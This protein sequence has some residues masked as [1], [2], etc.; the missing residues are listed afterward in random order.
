MTLSRP[1]RHDWIISILLISGLGLA[2]WLSRAALSGPFL[3]DDFPN[4][5]NLREI[6]GCFN[7]DRIANYLAVFT[8]TP[9]RPLSALSFLIDD[10]A[11][12]STPYSWKRH[13]LL[14]HLLCGLLVFGL[15]RSLASVRHTRKTSDWVGMGVA[16]AWLVHPMQLST[17]MLT[18]QRMTQL[19]TM[20]S[21][22]TCWWV[23][24]R[25]L[26]RPRIWKEYAKLLVIGGAMT[27]VAFLFKENGALLPLYLAA[28]S[29]WVLQDRQIPISRS[30]RAYFIVLSLPVAAII[31]ALAYTA[32]THQSDG[33]R[34]FNPWERLLTEGRILLDY[35]RQILFPRLNG[36][37][38]FHDDIVVSRG[39]LSPPTTL[40]ALLALL[41]LFL[42]TAVKRK[43]WPILAFAVVW[44]F[45]GHLLESTTW[46]LELYFE[47][48]NYLPMVGILAAIGIAIPDIASAKLKS[49]AKLAVLVWLVMCAGM[50][51]ST[52]S[53]WGS[54]QL[55]SAIW[56]KEHPNSLRSIE[57]QAKYLVDNH[58]L[59]A[60]DDL[61]TEAIRR[62][63]RFNGLAIHVLLVDCYSG[64]LTPQKMRWAI[65]LLHDSSFNRSTLNSITILREA[66]RDHVCGNSEMQ[67]QWITLANTLLHNPAYSNEDVKSFLYVE[68][69]QEGMQRHDFDTVVRN[70][71]AA[72]AAA[73]NATLAANL[74]YLLA[75]GGYLEQAEY[76]HQR[77]ERQSLPWPIPWW[78][79]WK[80]TTGYSSPSCRSSH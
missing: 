44:F 26:T 80:Q 63:S 71:E 47:H 51:L 78:N 27:L 77:A 73:P 65:E 9:G 21:L 42:L 43:K 36:S 22:A 1:N 2:W 61:M 29:A 69:M 7:G 4:F 50:T 12:P 76:W 79:K 55:Q 68:L 3:F 64:T 56:A 38:I 24:H 53:I 66:F 25:L 13:N 57:S 5:Q 6:S 59:P 8:D 17:S 11:W 58:E 40:L 31:I 60:A 46:P 49:V 16:A 18:V 15:A 62:D 23:S 74:A 19:M 10:Y 75:D 70:L 52:S 14:L 48:R 41:G 45:G 72:Y 28:T 39:L 34:P 30:T 20:V 67:Q 32:L 54:E 37:G 35:L 33:I